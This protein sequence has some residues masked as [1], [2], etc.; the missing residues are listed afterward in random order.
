MGALHRPLLLCPGSFCPLWCV[1]LAFFQLHMPWV[2][3]WPSVLPISSRPLLLL[4]ACGSS[5]AVRAW[6]FILQQPCSRHVRAFW[7]LLV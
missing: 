2:G 7:L 3:N 5:W 6:T 4:N 1:F